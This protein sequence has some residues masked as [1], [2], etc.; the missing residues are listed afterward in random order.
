ML[1][2]ATLTTTEA[3]RDLYNVIDNVHRRGKK[4]AF[5]HKGKTAAYI[6][7]PDEME[8]LMETIAIQSDPEAMRKIREGERELQQG[9]VVPWEEVKRK[10]NLH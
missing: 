8:S 3:R 2:D 10:L 4:Y 5:T 7:P 6:I 9:N 1:A